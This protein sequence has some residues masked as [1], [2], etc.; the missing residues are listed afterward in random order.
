MPHLQNEF[1]L[2]VSIPEVKTNIHAYKII[3]VILKTLKN[4]HLGEVEKPLIYQQ[5]CQK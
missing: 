5:T 4:S 2:G 1:K 3:L